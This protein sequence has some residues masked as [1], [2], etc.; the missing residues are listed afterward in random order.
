MPHHDAQQ[1]Q[2]RSNMVRAAKMAAAINA[3]LG[4]NT[5]EGNRT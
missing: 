5:C 2:D 1:V 4:V 3:K